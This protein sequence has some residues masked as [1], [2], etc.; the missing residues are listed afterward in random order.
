MSMAVSTAKVDITPSP[1][2]NPYLGGYGCADVPRQVTTGTPHAEPLYARCVVFWDDGSPNAIVSADVLA[3]PRSMHQRIRARVVALSDAWASS[4][5]VLQ[6]THTHNGPVLVDELNPEIAYN[7]SDL[8]LVTSYSAWLETQ[9]VTLVQTAL[10]APPVACTLDYRIDDEDFAFNRE[11]LPYVERAVPILTARRDDGTPVAVLFGYACH[12]VAA[13]TQTQFDGD[14]PGGACG[15]IERNLPGC[16]PL[17]VQG[18]AGDQDPNLPRDWAT[19]DAYANDLGATVVNAI[20]TPGRTVTGPI[21]T[22]YA[23][24]ALPLDVTPTPPNLAAVRADYVI[25]QSGTSLP[26]WYNRHATAMIAE[27]DA[28]TFATTIPLPIQVWRL[29]GTPLLRLVLAGGEVVSGYAVYFRARYGGTDG[30]WLCGY[31]NEIP[32]YIASDELLPPIRT[33]GSYD[34]GW[35]PDFP[36]IAG[37]AMT[38]YAWLGHF[39][40]GAGGVESTFIDAVTAQ[41]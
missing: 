32:A 20:A 22:S 27:I 25:R 4:D 23:E 39:K 11:G 8:T 40:A 36:G 2:A 6:A 15:F 31:A 33:G 38:V 1:A 10:G 29:Q 21:L 19:R 37:G 3:F 17:F 35:D 9:I 13:G 5:F 16:F 26:A 14:W 18:A 24:V 28:G 12:P 34:G 30:I 7:L 41:L